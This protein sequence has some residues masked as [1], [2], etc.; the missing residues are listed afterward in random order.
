MPR[1][2][3]SAYG[4]VRRAREL[5]RAMT[6]AEWKLWAV[7]RGGRLRDSFRRQHPIGQ[8]FADFY[9]A[10]LKLVVELDGSQ[11]VERAAYDE[12]RSAFLRMQS[13]EV[14]RF[15]NSDVIENVEGVATE[16]MQAMRKRRFAFGLPDT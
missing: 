13:I 6:K 15:W 10:P 5:R 4:K 8:F 7:M 14:I 9:C 1:S 11:H 16:I 12:A 2:F 3:S